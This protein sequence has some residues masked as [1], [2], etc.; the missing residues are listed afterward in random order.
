MEAGQRRSRA[1]SRRR[2]VKPAE[3]RGFLGDLVEIT[4]R[5][6]GAHVDPRLRGMLEELARRAGERLA[7]V[8]ADAAAEMDPY[9]LLGVKPSSTWEEIRARWTF[10]SKIAH[11]DKGGDAKLF[12]LMH[13]AY[14]E[15]EKRHKP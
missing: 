3:V 4:F 15:L 8:N 13:A 2:A 6:F 9:L 11:P 1:S 7:Q 10:L 5:H 12:D 14:L